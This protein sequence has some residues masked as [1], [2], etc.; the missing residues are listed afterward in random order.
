MEHLCAPVKLVYVTSSSLYDVIF[1]PY[2]FVQPQYIPDEMPYGQHAEPAGSDSTVN[3]VLYVPKPHI[4]AQRFHGTIIYCKIERLL[5][6]RYI[7]TEK[8]LYV[9]LLYT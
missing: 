3:T 7:P 4:T 9:F 6:T 5:C 2:N 8:L 1:I